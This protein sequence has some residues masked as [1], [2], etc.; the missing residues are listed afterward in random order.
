MY[1]TLHVDV[2]FLYHCKDFYRTWLY[3][4]VT[5]WVSCKKQELLTFCEHLSS[6]PFFLVGSVL[7]ISLVF[8]CCPFMCLYVLSSVLCLFPNKMMFGSSL[9]ALVC[10][11]ALVLFTFVCVCLHIMVYLFCFSLSYV[12]CVASFS[13]LSFSIDPSVFPNV[14]LN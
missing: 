9:P 7:L 2:S 1:F 5:Q 8:F 4:W 3:I 10:R 14:Y 12:P 13:G 11:R 6:S